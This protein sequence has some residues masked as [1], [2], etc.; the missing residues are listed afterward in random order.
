MIFFHILASCFLK[1]GSLSRWHAVILELSFCLGW[2]WIYLVILQPPVFGS[3]MNEVCTLNLTYVINENK[4]LDA[5]ILQSA[6][7][8]RKGTKRGYA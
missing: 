1:L 5:D 2:L 7:K 4:K 8:V 3:S 6:L